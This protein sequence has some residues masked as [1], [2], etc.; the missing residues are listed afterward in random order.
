MDISKDLP[1]SITLE[2]Q[3]EEWAQT[4]DYEHVPFRCRKCHEHG[5]LFRECPLN[6]PP[7]LVEEENTKNGFTQVQNLKNKMQRKPTVKN[8]RKHPNTNSF[9]DLTKLPQAEEVEN[10]HKTTGADG[11]NNK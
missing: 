5:H 7:N 6:A 1:G 3:D 8:S 11:T 9:E 10:P 4:I 2:Y